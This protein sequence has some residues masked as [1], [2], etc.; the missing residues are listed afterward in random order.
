M[1]V[2]R[3]RLRGDHRY[4]MILKPVHNLP[5]CTLTVERRQDDVTRLFR[6]EMVCT[7]ENVE[8]HVV[9][10]WVRVDRKMRL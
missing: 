2:V 3:H 4:A 9:I 6:V 7:T 10:L 1:P 5:L 8:V